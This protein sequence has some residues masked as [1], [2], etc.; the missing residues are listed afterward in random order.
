[1]GVHVANK[2][3]DLLTSSGKA[4]E[5]VRVGIMGLSFKENV[6]DL[7]NSRVPDIVRRL[8]E[9]GIRAFVH[10][11][12][13]NA[14]DAMRQYGI[15]LLGLEMMADLDGLVLA[16]PHEDYLKIRV[17]R[18][19]SFLKPDSILMD[20]KSALNPTEIPLGITYWSL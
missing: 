7:R 3:V 20:V 8:S 1:M 6:P 19:C 2:M 12:I 17:A 15:E 14:E 18:L 11:P 16:V 4:L 10:D 5:N 13:A 9:C